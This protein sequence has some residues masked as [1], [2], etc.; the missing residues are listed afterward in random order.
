MH[1]TIAKCE[2]NPRVFRIDISQENGRRDV[3]APDCFHWRFGETHEA[4]AEVRGVNFVLRSREPSVKLLCD[5][6]KGG[7]DH[8]A[9]LASDGVVLVDTKSGGT[10]TVATTLE[11]RISGLTP[12]KHSIVSYH[13][14]MNDHEP[15][16]LSME[17]DGVKQGQC[18]PSLRVHHDDDCSSIWGEFEARSGHDVVVHWKSDTGAPPAM[19]LNGFAIDVADPAYQ[20]RK[21]KPFDGDEHADELPRLQWT[22][23]SGT[24]LHQVYFGEDYNRVL[25][26]K[27][28]SPEFVG[29]CAE[30]ELGLPVEGKRQSFSAL[31]P[32]KEYYWRVDSLAAGKSE[33]MVAGRVWR[34]KV[35]R[36][37]FPGAEG[38][39]R[40]ARGGMG[41]RLIEVTNLNDNGPGSLRDAVEAVGPRIVVFRVGGTITLK[42]K[43]VIR[44]PYITIAGQ[45]APG[46]G[47]CV[48]GYTFGCFGTHDVIMRYVR[49][50]V[51]DEAHVTMDGTGFASTD[52]AIMDHCSVSWSIDEG[53]SSRGASNITFQ[54]CIVAEALNIAD[55]KK[56]QPGK[57]H[58]FAASI[59]G[60]IGSFHHNLFAHCA[61]RNWS[62]A[63]GLEKGGGFAGR[64]DIRN[65]VVYNWEHR[66]TDGGVKALNFVNNLYIPGPATRVFH[67][68]K[69][70]AGTEKDPQQYFV[71]GNH[72]EG[73]DYDAD[74]WNAKS[75]V[76]DPQLLA[77]IRLDRPF[78]D[79]YITEQSAD[80]AYNNVMEDVGANLPALDSLDSRILEDVRLRRAVTRGSRSGIPGIIDSQT[81]SGGWPEL[82]TGTPPVDSDHDGL[83]DSWEMARGLDPTDPLDS[84]NVN[85]QF[86]SELEI[87]LN[88]FTSS[89]VSAR[90]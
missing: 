38:Y 61:G 36:L 85:S 70:D 52:H 11:L 27:P 88:S 89:R 49:I 47:I 69:P 50:R 10:N 64:L 54:R 77:R 12:G 7:F 26:A 3:L 73:K 39:G 15:N 66:T 16:S 33:P 32:R 19:V 58:S 22:S 43:L 56:Y 87:Y 80:D 82:A 71:S 51:G 57:G 42:S 86:F 62:L 14:W 8:P 34:F 29:T 23:P 45:T 72:M 20:A 79:S 30:S 78:C 17:I 68:L 46:G 25:H 6:W 37:A 13:N 65:N 21:P 59:S 5:W 2:E 53:V 48:R 81:D 75:V 24:A 44:N 60:N 1:P 28:T 90:H 31:D 41:G 18:K 9:A 74:N 4:S 63:G 35:R 40:F 84:Q 83:P 76:V 55:H 67:L